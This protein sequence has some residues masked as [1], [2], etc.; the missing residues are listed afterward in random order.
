M[1]CVP[2]FLIP[3]MAI[4]HPGL[5]LIGDVGDTVW[6][7]ANVLMGFAAIAVALI[8][9]LLRPIGAVWR[10]YFAL[11]GLLSLLSDVGSSAACAALLL[12]GLGWQ[13]LAI[14]RARA[15]APSAVAAGS[16]RQP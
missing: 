15:G 14:R 5:L 12:V 16:T 2:G 9:W 11:V 3:F 7:L 13:A 10:I 6:G 4:V 8:G 1:L